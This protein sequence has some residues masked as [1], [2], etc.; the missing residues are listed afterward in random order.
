MNMDM[1]TYYLGVIFKF[2]IGFV[3]GLELSTRLIEFALKRLRL[4]REFLLFCLNK[5]KTNTNKE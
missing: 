4:H 5:W 1:D 2:I 3:A